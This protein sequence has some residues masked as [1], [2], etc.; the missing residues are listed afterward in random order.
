MNLDTRKKFPFKK[1]KTA[2]QLIRQGRF[3]Y[4]SIVAKRQIMAFYRRNAPYWL[5]NLERR[6]AARSSRQEESFKPFLTPPFKV[7]S[8][9]R[10]EPKIRAAVILDDFSLACWEHEFQVTLLTPNN[11][12]SKIASSQFDLLFVESAWQGNN[13]AWSTRLSQ[14]GQ[15][16]PVLQ[17]I[18]TAFKEFDIPTAFWNKEDPPHFKQFIATA[19]MFDFVFTTDSN[20]IP[21]YERH[22]GVGRAFALPFAAQPIIHNPA[23][24]S[25]GTPGVPDPRWHQGD[26]AFAGSYFKNK[27]PERRFQLDTLLKAAVTLANENFKFS[28]FSR[29]GSA[30][31]NNR[32]PSYA[33]PYVIGSLQYE[34]M[35]SANKE[36]KVFINVNTVTDSPTMCARRIFEVPAC[37]TAVLT[38]P[39]PATKNFFSDS[40]LV[41]ATD[42]ATALSSLSMLLK[43]PAMRDRVNHRA[44]R[45]I[46]NE[47]TYRH[48][49][50]KV[51]K[52]LG[53]PSDEYERQLAVPRVS[54]ICSTNRPSQV[55]HLIEQVARQVNV[56]IQLII[57]THGFELSQSHKLLLDRTFD[58]YKVVVT[59]SS[60]S[61]GDCLN[62]CVNES[63]FDYVA[64]FDDD[65]IYLPHYLEDQINTLKFSGA[66]L[67]G[68]QA[69]YAFVESRNALMLR[70]PEREHMWTNFVAGPTFVGPRATFVSNPFESRT[71]GEDSEFLRSIVNGGGH[72]YSADRFNFIQIRHKN[73]HTWQL[74]DDDFL[75]QGTIESFGFNEA[76][77]EA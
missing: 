10:N 74:A 4:V 19:K 76:H 65:D 34:Y 47:H 27:F 8:L 38:M 42:S 52:A 43:S 20:M 2:G 21:E 56:E 70:R 44:Q 3:N 50:L 28:I 63:L 36:H 24:N 53:I 39:T 33:K 32:F 41:T 66:S 45:K 49:A 54:V 7:R 77:A 35:L 18:V 23:R 25:P 69:A 9:E 6:F 15:V 48:R 55:P 60:M 40:E 13:G 46:W 16:D 57:A 75:A 5:M 58:D 11:W 14:P 17:E 12:R 29:T 71:T 1:L 62:A 37:G 26:I 73:G 59:D 61:L 72:I 68:K 22:V 30:D 67:V 64:K 51:A 31:P